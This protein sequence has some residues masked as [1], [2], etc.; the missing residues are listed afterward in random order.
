MF[1]FVF[2]VPVFFFVR[3]VV[4]K[5]RVQGQKLPVSNY[6]LR[7]ARYRLHVT[8]CLCAVVAASF[9]LRISAG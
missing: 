1:L 7:V 6:G 2:F 3:F 9:S 5:N 8:S 4:K